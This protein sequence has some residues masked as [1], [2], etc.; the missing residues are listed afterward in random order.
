MAGIRAALPRAA[1]LLAA[2]RPGE[3]AFADRIM[4]VERAQDK[5]SQ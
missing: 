3:I 1:I 5:T 4:R 2:H